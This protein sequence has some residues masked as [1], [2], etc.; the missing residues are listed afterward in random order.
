VGET[1]SAFMELLVPLAKVGLGFFVG[2]MVGL[3]GVG[4]AALMTPSLVIFLRMNPVTA[5]ATDLLYAIVTDIVGAAQHIRQKNAELTLS[6]A[7]ALGA[8]PTAV[9]GASILTTLHRNK[10]TRLATEKYL[11]LGLGIL[12][13]GISSMILWQTFSSRWANRGNGTTAPRPQPVRKI[14]FRMLAVGFAIGAL[15][16]LVVGMTSIGAGCLVVTALVFIFKIPM[17][18]IVGTTIVVAAVLVTSGG[19]THLLKGNAHPPTAALLLIGSL[20]GVI[21]GSKLAMHAPGTLLKVIVSLAIL[22]SGITLVVKSVR[23]REVEEPLHSPVQ[24]ETVSHRA[25]ATPHVLAERLY[26][27]LPNTPNPAASPDC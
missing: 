10:A 12:L 5:V 17:R 23:D 22:T 14:P 1:N 24:V 11:S 8:A 6:I 7:I 4:G 16:G 18:R 27:L 20:P 21:L 26:E 2:F 25:S 3:T 13:I 9:L 15:I 19:I